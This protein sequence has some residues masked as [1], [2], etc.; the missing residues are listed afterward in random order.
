MEQLADEDEPLLFLPFPF[1]TKEVPQLPYKGSDPEWSTFV[2]L[3]KDQQLQKFVKLG[4]AQLIRRG[5]E[6]NPAYVKVLG[7]KN[8]QVKKFWLDIIYPP[9]PP[10]KHYVSGIIIDEEGIFWGD[11]PIDSVAA[12]HLDM[13]L[14]PKAVA[15]SVWAFVNSLAKKTAE[16]IFK[17]LGIRT[18]PPSDTTWQSAALDRMREQGVLGRP[19]KQPANEPDRSAKPAGSP[20]PTPGGDIIGNPISGWGPVDPR[21]QGALQAASLTF[22]KNWQPA[23]QP[24]RRG[25]VRVDGLVELQ[26]KTAVMAVFVL[27]WYDPKEMTFFGIQT[28]LKHLVQLKQR[29]A[30]G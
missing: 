12:S 8:I 25:C 10:P 2:T 30:S 19:S 20:M 9:R 24:Q 11:R 15:L 29:P 3:N 22:S 4:L 23:R 27:A 1:T 18:P 28:G 21:I 7:G 13:A 5:V 17:A 16:D 6:R 26:G 14:Y